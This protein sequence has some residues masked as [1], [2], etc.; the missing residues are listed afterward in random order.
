MSKINPEITEQDGRLPLVKLLLDL[1]PLIVF[2][3]V[4]ALYGIFAATGAFMAAMAVSLAASRA[5][6]GKISPMPVFTAVLVTVF[7]GLTLY[8]QDETFIKVKPTVLY[9]LFA[10]LLLFGLATGRMFLRMLMGEAIAL[11]NEGWKILTLRWVWFFLALAALNEIVWRTMSTDFWVAF[12]VFG[13]LPLTFLFAI[14]QT[15]LVTK[16]HGEAESR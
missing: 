16:H 5:L 9:A 2:F 11:T 1:G 13:L 10:A 7:G 8:L 4:N 12:K 14:V 15:G 6:L 3:T